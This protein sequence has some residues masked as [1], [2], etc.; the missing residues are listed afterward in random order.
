[1]TRYAVHGN[2]LAVLTDFEQDKRSEV[3]SEHVPF[4]RN[5]F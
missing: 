2:P 4:L 3:S 5:Q 1:V